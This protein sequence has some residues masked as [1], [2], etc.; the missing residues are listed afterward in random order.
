MSDTPVEIPTRQDLRA[1]IEFV[2]V[3][4]TEQKVSGGV[5]VEEVFYRE[6]DK[7]YWQARYLA[8]NSGYVGDKLGDGYC[9]PSELVQVKPPEGVAETPEGKLVDGE[10]L[11]YT[12]IVRIELAPEI[13][14]TK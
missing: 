3:R 5:N 13:E 8:S 6:S 2:S 11:D 12:P 9:D 7:T 1:K 14:D 10:T 4:R